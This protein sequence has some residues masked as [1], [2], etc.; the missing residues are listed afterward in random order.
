MLAKVGSFVCH[1]VCV[2]VCGYV[3]VNILTYFIVCQLFLSLSLMSVYSCK[4]GMGTI[5]DLIVFCE[6][7]TG[8][9][10]NV[11]LGVWK[12]RIITCFTGVFV[13][14]R[15]KLQADRACVRLRVTV[16]HY[17][18]WCRYLWN[19]KVFHPSLF[20]LSSFYAPQQMAAC[21]RSSV[22]HSFVWISGIIS[23]RSC[24]S[25]MIIRV[26]FITGV[27]SV[28]SSE[29]NILW[30]LWMAAFGKKLRFKSQWINIHSGTVDL[31]RFL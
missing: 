7:G 8:I 20:S 12:R 16:C 3:C 18:H 17:T 2:C 29:G 1:P 13:I 21:F 9:S 30:R 24:D 10:P 19:P 11:E 5:W 6:K 28:N 15:V 4:T 27:G 26:F 14:L 25:L 31:S 23:R 22:R